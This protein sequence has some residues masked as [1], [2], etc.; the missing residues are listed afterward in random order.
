MKFL[1]KVLPD[2][3]LTLEGMAVEENENKSM[4]GEQG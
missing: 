4:L 2:F 1:P 3:S